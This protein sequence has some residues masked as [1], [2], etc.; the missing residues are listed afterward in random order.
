MEQLIEFVGNHP[1]LSGGFVAVL[2]FLIW[3]EVVRK[4]QGLQELTP[5]QAVAWVNDP[6]AAVVD[7]SPAADF[8]KGHII[9]AR[10]LPMSRIVGTDAEIRKLI[11]RKVL[12]VCKSGQN[13]AQAAATLKKL[14]IKEVAVLKGGMVRWIG[15]QYPVTTR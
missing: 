2:V 4:L 10:N 7:V 14:G 1:L 9:N 8:N 3:T 6:Q 5:L 11:D 13:S 15:D 12:V